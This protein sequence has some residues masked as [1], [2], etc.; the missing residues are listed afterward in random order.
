MV[1]L[2]IA[3]SRTLIE[4]SVEIR[5][6]VD[7]ILTTMNMQVDEIVSGNAAG[8]DKIGESYAQMKNIRV[9]SMPADWGKYGR[10]AGPIRNKQ[11]AHYADVG[12]VFWDGVSKGSLN[13]IEEMSK[14][15]K[16]CLVHI[17]KPKIIPQF[18]TL[19]I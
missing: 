17:I 18:A 19:P 5:K 4:E 16:P 6:T 9:T 3:G 2:I 13:M 12:I 1:K 8:P 7:N 14:L 10:A 15:N 11:M